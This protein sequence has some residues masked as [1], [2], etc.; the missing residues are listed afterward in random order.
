M[1]AIEEEQALVLKEE[2]F[3][4]QIPSL[5][6]VFHLYYGDVS[7]LKTQRQ[8]LAKNTLF[9]VLVRE[10]FAALDGLCLLLPSTDDR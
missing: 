3:G 10:N 4:V 8:R 6:I 2:V 5:S 9:A 1:H 7:R